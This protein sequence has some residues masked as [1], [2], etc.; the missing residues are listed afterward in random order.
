MEKPS[1]CTGLCTQLVAA[2]SQV[3]ITCPTSKCNLS[4]N[5]ACLKCNRTLEMIIESGYT[6]NPSYPNDDLS[7][8]GKS[9]S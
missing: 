8:T 7:K 1:C 3:R 9:S 4:E 5:V 2:Y 6:L